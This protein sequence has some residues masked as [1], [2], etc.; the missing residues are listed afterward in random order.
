MTMK[1]KMFEEE[2][3]KKLMKNMKVAKNKHD[4]VPSDV[5]NNDECW[6]DDEDKKKNA[7]QEKH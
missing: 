7:S 5:R 3:P 1:L 4:G 6:M 2:K